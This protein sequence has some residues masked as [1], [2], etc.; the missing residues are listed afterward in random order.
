MYVVMVLVLPVQI[1]FLFS[2]FFQKRPLWGA[3]LH[4]WLASMECLSRTQVSSVWAQGYLRPVIWW[5]FFII[6]HIFCTK[7]DISLLNF[8]IIVCATIGG[9]V[10]IS[11]IKHE[12][13]VSN[14]DILKHMF[15]WWIKSLNYPHRKL[16]HI[17]MI[18]NE[19]IQGR[20]K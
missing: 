7:I 10:N 13:L 5:P 6:K 17:K 11:T 19:S 1:S 3:K 4:A 14:H 20:K 16:S 15:P 18:K 9:Q 8:W 2:F 12:S